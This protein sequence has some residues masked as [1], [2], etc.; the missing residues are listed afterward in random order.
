MTI[1]IG[2]TPTN[3]VEVLGENGLFRCG[4][5]VD[6]DDTGLFVDFHCASRQRELVPFDNV[7]PIS[8]FTLNGKEL[9]QIYPAPQLTSHVDVLMRESPTGPLTWF[10]AELANLGRGVQHGS[11]DVAIVHWWNTVACTDVVPAQRIRRSA[12]T[13]D[14]S[15]AEAAVLRN[16]VP[17]GKWTFAKGSVQLPLRYASLTM[18]ALEQLVNELNSRKS[19]FDSYSQRPVMIVHG[20]KE[21]LFYIEQRFSKYQPDVQTTCFD[22]FWTTLDHVVHES[23]GPPRLVRILADPDTT[24]NSGISALS[25]NVLMEIFSCLSTLK[26]TSL[27]NVCASWNYIMDLPGIYANVIVKIHGYDKLYESDRSDY[28]LTAPI[29]KCLRATTKRLVADCRRPMQQ[30]GE[31][32]KVLDMIL[33]AAQHERI[34]LDTI[35]LIGIQGRL[36]GSSFYCNVHNTKQFLA[37]RERSLQ[38]AHVSL[39]DFT[40]ACRDLPC[41]AVQLIGCSFHLGFSVSYRNGHPLFMDVHRARLQ[42]RGDFDLDCALWGALEA[43]L[44]APSNDQLQGLSQWLTSAAA[45]QIDRYLLTPCCSV[46]CST[47][48]VDPRAGAHWR[49]KRWCRDGL[50]ELRWENLSRMALLSL[51]K[52]VELAM[53]LRPV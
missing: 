35:F 46:L 16:V 13:S 39:R 34:R 31:F 1:S 26:Q 52:V 29:F 17:V 5:V 44:P 50:A 38:A 12:L 18:P 21:Q 4:S 43:V 40:V 3:S 10:P 47:Q 30:G 49:G 45:G 27:R 53:A 14:A 7:F 48:T 24:D 15:N 37:P 33:C 22:K 8:S 20:E 32:L 42:R 28:L 36:V 51:I 6:V 41:D 9:A 23:K 25:E 11:Y 2:D 19:L